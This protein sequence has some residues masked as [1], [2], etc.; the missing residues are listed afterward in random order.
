M[1]FLW[2]IQVSS[3]YLFTKNLFYFIFFDFRAHWTSFYRK[4]RGF[5]TKYPRLRKQSTRMAGCFRDS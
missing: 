2:N 5:G 4:D 1:N 3:N